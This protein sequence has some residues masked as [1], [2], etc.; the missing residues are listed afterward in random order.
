MASLLLVRDG[1]RQFV[2]ET[3]IVLRQKANFLAVNRA[4][5]LQTLWNVSAPFPRCFERMH[6]YCL[7]FDIVVGIILHVG[8]AWFRP[9]APCAL[10]GPIVEAE[11]RTDFGLLV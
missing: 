8:W 11:K 2:S 3:A 9:V 5:Q 4:L 1:A 10:V 7:S 6:S